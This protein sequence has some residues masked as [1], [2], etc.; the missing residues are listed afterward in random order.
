MMKKLLQNKFLTI[1]ALC[2]F[3]LSY[4]AQII[5]LFAGTGATGFSGNGGAATSAQLAGPYGVA[6]DATGNVYIADF[7]NHQIRKVN[8]SGI[9]STF[10]G[11]P[12]LGFSGDGGAATSAQLNY[13]MGVAADA[14]GNIYIADNGNNRIRKVNTSGI[15]STFAG[16]GVGGFSG[17][18]AAA[19]LAQINAPTGVATDAAGNVYIVDANNDRIRKVNTS[20][21]ISTIAGT[22]VGGFSGDGAAATL[23][24]LN[25]PSGVTVD[26][27]G[28]IYIADMT[29]QRIRKINTS[30]IISTYAGV[31]TAGF[32]GD[33]GLATSAQINY[34]RGLAIDALGNV[35]IADATNHRIRVINTSSI[36]STAAGTGTLGYSGDGGLATSAQ[37]NYPRGVAFDAAG[38]VY[39]AD[40]DNNRI[41][42]ITSTTGIKNILF[43]TNDYLVYPNPN[44]G[45]FN[46]QIGHQLENGFIIIY[47]S[48]GQEMFKQQ[49]YQQQ[50][51]ID[52]NCSN[53]IYF[54]TISKDNSILSTGK[55]V[56]E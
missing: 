46:L 8:T 29:N 53:G 40:S 3:S 25:N 19:N 24:Q 20:G 17:D 9:I 23:A 28:N 14:A 15:I 16:T 22:G 32:S 52:L 37:I 1:V 47:N 11:Q 13:P 45:S 18:G 34:P 50:I 36:I 48:L 10:A 12:A 31:G 42:K 43:N 2:L 51:S 7:V 6:V 30:G 38:N 41:R 56:I 35:Y 27:A 5:N 21:I 55:M 39:I 49:I 33:G 4:N 26:A 44:K 54:Y